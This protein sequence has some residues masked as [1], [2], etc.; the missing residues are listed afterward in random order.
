MSSID[1]FTIKADTVMAP[2]DE[3][4]DIDVSQAYAGVIC[5]V[6]AHVCLRT[7][8]RTLLHVV[9]DIFCAMDIAAF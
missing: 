3:Y 5:P 7:S 2:T 8:I 6:G 4:S 1:R 9:L